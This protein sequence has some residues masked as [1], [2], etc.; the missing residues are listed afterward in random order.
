MDEFLVFIK[1]DLGIVLAWICTVFGTLFG[2][3]MNMKNNKLKAEIINI[4]QS[5]ETT[6]NSSDSI[7]QQ[8]KNNIYTKNNS[9]DMNIKM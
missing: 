3:V 6:D 7:K 1:S 5:Y 4:K 8:G 2:I 9:G